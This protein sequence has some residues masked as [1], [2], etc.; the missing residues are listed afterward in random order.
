MYEVTLWPVL[1]AAVSSVLIGFIWYNPHVFGTAWMRLAGI[2]PSTMEAGKKTMPLMA[3]FGFLASL[4]MAYV[5][6][7]FG[8]AWGVFDWL[9]A[10]ELAFWLWLGFIVPAMLGIVLWEGKSF[11]LYAINVSYWLVAMIVM[12]LILTL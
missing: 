12:A 9:S 6:A 7:H 10:I 4:V 8:V 5:M 11:K 3:F 1:A 2:S